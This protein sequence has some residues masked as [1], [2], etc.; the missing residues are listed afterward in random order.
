[1]PKAPPPS[2]PVDSIEATKYAFQDNVYYLQQGTS[3]NIQRPMGRQS[4]RLHILQIKDEATQQIYK[5]ATSDMRKR[6]GA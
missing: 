1:M 6:P 2:P 3:E 5:I 4:L